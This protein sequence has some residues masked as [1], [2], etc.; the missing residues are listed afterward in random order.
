M[1]STFQAKVSSHIQTEIDNMVTPFQAK[2]QDNLAP[3]QTKL[4]DNLTQFQTKLPTV[5][6]LEIQATLKTMPV[7]LAAAAVP[8]AKMLPI[9]GSI[10]DSIADKIGVFITKYYD[11]SMSVLAQTV[12]SFFVPQ[13]INPIFHLVTRLT[14]PPIG[15]LD[16]KSHTELTPDLISH[17]IGVFIKTYYDLSMLVVTRIEVLIWFS[18]L[19]SAVTVQSW[20]WTMIALYTIFIRARYDVKDFARLE[21]DVDGFLGAQN[22]PLTSRSALK[23]VLGLTR[24]FYNVLG[25]NGYINKV[26]VSKKIKQL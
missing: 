17:N 5:L 4:Q 26:L 22:V 12:I 24:Q 14:A 1:M 10:S 25:L 11:M 20:S 19:F 13:W 6:N 2:L 15:T 9:S 3:F 8:D 16:A 21:A 18:L 23:S 7:D